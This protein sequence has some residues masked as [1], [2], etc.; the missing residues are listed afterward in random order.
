MKIPDGWQAVTQYPEFLVEQG[1]DREGL[2]ATPF[3]MFNTQTKSSLQVD[4][5]P[6]GGTVRFSQETIEALVRMSGGGLVSEIHEEHSKG[7]PIKLSKVV[8]TQGKD[9]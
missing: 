8:P 6:A 1:Y 2:K 7:T 3:F 9:G 4:L 5:S